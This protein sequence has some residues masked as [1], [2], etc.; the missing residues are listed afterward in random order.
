MRADEENGRHY[1]FTSEDDF[2]RRM[3]N[4]EFA[5]SAQVHD[6]YYGTSRAFVDQILQN[7][8]VAL[9]DLDVQGGLQIKEAYPQSVLVFILPPSAE[10]LEG[11]LRG[12]ETDQEAVIKTRLENAKTEMTYWP[13]YDYVVINDQLDD[14]VKR[15][16][17]IIDAELCKV[18]RMKASE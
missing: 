17:A 11:R 1:H 14:A 10:E 16:Q 12:R 15:V 3:D 5:E 6:H 7:R 9:F 2:R 8:Q 4:E 18:S 13:K